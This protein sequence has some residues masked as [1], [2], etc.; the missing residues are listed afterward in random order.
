MFSLSPRRF[1]SLL[2]LAA[3]LPLLIAFYG[4][5]SA[6]RASSSY[7]PSLTQQQ[8]VRPFG[9]TVFESGCDDSPET[10][11]YNSAFF[12]DDLT[13]A[14]VDVTFEGGK[15]YK[16]DPFR[17]DSNYY[18]ARNATTLVQ[19]CGNFAPRMDLRF[20]RSV[21]SVAISVSAGHV[22]PFGESG[23]GHIVVNATDNLGRSNDFFLGAGSDQVGGVPSPEWLF[24]SPPGNGIDHVILTTTDPAW[25]LQIYKVEFTPDSAVPSPTPDQ[26]RNLGESCPN[27]LVGKPVN[28]TN[29]NM[30]LQ[31]SDYELP[32][33][34]EAISFTRTYNSMSSRSG[35]F[36]KGWSTD[37]DEALVINS[38]TSLRLYMPDGRATDFVGDGSGSFVPVQTDF[39]GQINQNANGTFS[40]SF[41]DGRVHVFTAFWSV[42]FII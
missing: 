42:T 33:A 36:G 22:T 29:G 17:T 28:V 27:Q 20:S 39:F 2:L 16:G 8:Q 41:K 18:G 19:P 6:N 35:L 7:S 13:E 32:G 12:D 10:I 5:V 34:G 3:V 14:P 37:Y 24:I 30:Y 11:T 25:V 23:I 40:L 4:R 9:A 1:H 38:P 31:Q 15:L 26:A 21:G